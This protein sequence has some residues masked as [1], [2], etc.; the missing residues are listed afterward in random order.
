MQRIKTVGLFAFGFIAIAMVSMLTLTPDTAQGVISTARLRAMQGGRP[1][2][3]PSTTFTCTLYITTTSPYANT[4]FDTAILLQ[5]T[6]I[7]LALFNGAPGDSV[8]VANNYFLLANPIPNNAYTV[9]AV[10]D[11]VGNY[12]LGIVVYDVARQAIA[13]DQNPLDN[14]SASITIVPTT[15]NPLFFEVLQL[16]P[17]VSRMCGGTYHLTSVQTAPPPSPSFGYGFVMAGPNNAWP[18]WAG[19]NWQLVFD[20]PAFSPSTELMR[21][22]VDASDVGNLT[23]LRSRMYRSVLENS[24]V[25]A[26]QIGNEP[27]LSSEWHAPPDALAY[28][29]TLCAAYSAIKQARPLAIVVS[30]GLAPT[31][32]VAGTWDGHLGHDGLK[33]DEREFLKEFIAVGGGSCLD[34]VGYNALGFR[35]NYD[36]APDVDGGSPETNCAS[37]LCFRS[38]EKAY[39]IMQS[40]G[41][42]AKPIWA[43]EVGW[44]LA[45][46]AAC[47][48]DPR[49]SGRT[50]QIVTPA[51]Q[52]EDLVGAFRYARL[53]WPWMG[54]MFVFNLDFNLAPW[55]DD[56]EQMRYYS[57]VGQ[58]AFLALARMPKEFYRQYYPVIRK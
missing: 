36:A 2:L 11:G 45:P 47:L 8:V 37:G 44:L 39:A 54:A 38:V 4:S 31:G 58:P 9:Q 49:W 29:L 50:W 48:S 46:P 26:F 22:K 13:G 34:A 15:T 23:A 21:L 42:G 25:E 32:R 19:F 16:V 3:A 18:L 10:P 20:S 33:Q 12:N 52:S 1:T 55:Y 40:G 27:N 43:T 35:A 5:Y 53:H 57:V 6:T 28:R 30:G 51:Q 14:N 56:C 24:S 41:L 17:F 7:G